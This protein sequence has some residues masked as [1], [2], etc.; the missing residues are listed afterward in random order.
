MDNPEDAA[1]AKQAYLEFQPLDGKFRDN[2]L[3]QIKNG[4]VDFQP[5]EPYS[6][7]FGSMPRSK[8]MV[9]FQITQEYLGFSNHL[10]FLAPLWKEFCAFVLAESF[11]AIAGVANSG[12]DTIGI[13]LQLSQSPW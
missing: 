9:E 12:T 3:V 6:P 2:V 7:L 1:R 13:G 4:P 5:R 8:T 11:E 10:A